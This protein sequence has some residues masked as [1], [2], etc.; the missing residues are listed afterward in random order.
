MRTRVI[1]FSTESTPTEMLV[2]ERESKLGIGKYVF[3][4][5]PEKK[6]KSVEDDT[7]GHDTS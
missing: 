1:T 5:N 4:I 7:V 3:R 6:E 2:E